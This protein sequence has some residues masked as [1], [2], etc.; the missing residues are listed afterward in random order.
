MD[1]STDPQADSEIC[2]V[3]I[4]KPDIARLD[5]L[6]TTHHTTREFFI[7][8]AVIQLLDQLEVSR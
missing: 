5:S 6:C 1:T 2:H 7:L 3:L 8:T 4:S